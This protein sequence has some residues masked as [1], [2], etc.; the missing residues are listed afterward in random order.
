MMRNG[1]KPIRG[2]VRSYLAK[3][4]DMVQPYPS[5][6]FSLSILDNHSRAHSICKVFNEEIPNGNPLCLTLPLNRL[7]VHDLCESFVF[8]PHG[9]P[10]RSNLAFTC[11]EVTVI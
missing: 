1:D 8:V 6:T 3:T 4:G 10:E 5:P 7:E 9:R 11:T 2:Q